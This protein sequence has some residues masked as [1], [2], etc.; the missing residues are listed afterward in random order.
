MQTA[1]LSYPSPLL[2]PSS[3]K[4]K[5]TML[6][7]TSTT[8][9]AFCE[10]TAGIPQAVPGSETSAA[11]HKA[12]KCRYIPEDTGWP[13]P[14]LWHQ[15]NRTVNGRLIATVPVGSV[16][17][18]PNY[19]EA[20]CNDLTA[21]W[22]LVQT[23]YAVPVPHLDNMIIPLT[24]GSSVP[25]PAEFLALYFQNNTCT[26]F[27]PTSTRCVLGNYAPYSIDV[28][29]I[30]DVRAGIIFARKRNIRLVIKNSGHESV[31]S[32][33]SCIFCPRLTEPAFSFYGQ[34]TGKGALSLWMHNYNK[35]ILIPNYSSSYYHGPALH[36]QTGAEAAAAGA[37]AS[38]QG[39]TVV[40]GSCPTVKL[41]RHFSALTPTPENGHS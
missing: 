1:R 18:F 28:R 25:R 19:D 38:A 15:L 11:I 14:Q 34:S 35:T 33:L 3:S 36:V 21:T 39:Y 27:T 12:I 17:H 5:G 22:G 37:Y 9:L 31:N 40:A 26:P 10:L 20:K 23:A 2:F 4:L 6:L 29:S 32:Y 13:Q 16:C 41:V 7:R 30:D 24:F 8:A